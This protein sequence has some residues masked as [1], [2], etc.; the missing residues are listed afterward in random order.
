MQMSKPWIESV[1][2]DD[3]KILHVLW[4]KLPCQLLRIRQVRTKPA[5]P[6]SQREAVVIELQAPW[7]KN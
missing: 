2:S 7:K 1:I 5:L 4:C 3:P 6:V